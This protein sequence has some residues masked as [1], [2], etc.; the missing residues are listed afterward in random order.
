MITKD[1]LDIIGKSKNVG[2]TFHQSPDGDSL[3]SATALLQGL[4]AL[5]KEAYILSKECIPS[6]F[7]YLP[8]SDEITGLVEDVKSGT[9]VVIVL[10]CGDFK[11]INANLDID[12]KKYTLIN[13]DHHMS[14]EKYGDLN[15]VDIKS[16]AVGEIVFDILKLLDVKI[17]KG[18]GESIYTSILTDTSSFRHSNTT[19][20]THEVA[21]EVVKAGINFNRIQRTVFEN[22]DFDKVKF[23][24][25]VIDTLSLEIRGKV[26]FMEITD[27]MLKKSNLES[28][29]SGEVIHFGTMINGVE[30][31]ALF[32]ESKGGIKTSLRSKEMVDVSKIAETF[33][34]GGHVRAAGFF[35]E[36]KMPSLK[37]KLRKILE[38]ELM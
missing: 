15:Y 25:K 7:E 13:I 21:G 24:G 10:D 30:V 2:I 6:T 37:I 22:K 35:Y 28:M 9:D 19:S 4:R 18:I 23:F 17:T 12:N 8:C 5:G 31:V 1:I 11:R 29:D 36:G 38:K 16:A 34:G 32:K 27:E 3:G 14:N 26:A 33:N 20:K